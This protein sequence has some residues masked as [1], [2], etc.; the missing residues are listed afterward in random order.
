MIVCKE[1]GN[2]AESVDGF[3]SSCG[4]LLE[5]SGQPV[6]AAAGTGTGTDAKLGTRQPEPERGR[7]DPVP[8]VE[9]PVHTGLY[10]SACGVRNPHGRTFCRSCGEPLRGVAAAAEQRPGWWR[11][12][13]NRLRGKPATPAPGAPGAAAA[14]PGAAAGTAEGAA[15]PGGGAGAGGSPAGSRL[16]PPGQQPASSLQPPSGP[17]HP[18]FPHLPSAGHHQPHQ[19][20]WPQGGLPG[21]AGQS[22]RRTQ[23]RRRPSFRLAG[24]ALALLGLLGIGISPLGGKIE[25]WVENWFHHHVQPGRTITVSPVSAIASSA[26]PGHPAALAID[27]PAN[28]FWLTGGDSGVGASITIRFA[29]AVSINRISILSG[30]PGAGYFTQGRPETVTVTGGSGRP[31]SITFA[32]QSSFQTQTV[33]LQNVTSV[34]LTIAS[35]YDGQRGQSVAI[36]ELQFTDLIPA[37]VST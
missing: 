33:S 3:C 12:L 17:R 20:H 24:S 16:G 27:G 37:S 35:E 31:Q 8:L 5:W 28:T 23:Y 7:P 15:A 26:A 18:G 32:D 19:P 9:E 34:T 36:S 6:P 1:C 22:I 11:R 25:K 2:S 14:E 4:V 21:R 30:E 29:G 10:C 13:M